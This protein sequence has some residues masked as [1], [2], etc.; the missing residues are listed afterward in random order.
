V[1]EPHLLEAGA[2]LRL[3]RPLEAHAALDSLRR[4][5]PDDPAIEALWG[6]CLLTEHRAQEALPS[7]EHA[8]RALEDDADL[9]FALGM[10]RASLGRFAEARDAFAHAVAIDPTLYDGWLR[11][12]Q[13][14]HLAGDI[15]TH[16]R[17]L[18]AAAALPEARDGR[19]AALRAR[20]AVAPPARP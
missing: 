18:A 2:L 19:A 6:E 1:L 13:A 4:A 3:G 12:A 20:N 16:E 14:A 11:L 9:A 5:W 8:A 15:A 7:L 10:A 17:A